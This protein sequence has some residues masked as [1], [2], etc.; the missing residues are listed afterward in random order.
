ML[1]KWV[2]LMNIIQRVKLL[3]IVIKTFWERNETRKIN[4]VSCKHYQQVESFLVDDQCLNYCSDCNLR[5]DLP[6]GF[7]SCENCKGFGVIY[8]KSGD[9][10]HF[11][12]CDN[13]R[14][15]GI[16]SWTQKILS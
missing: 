13:C 7:E 6:E 4:S 3:M 16:I 9:S 8:E 1:Q 2:L 11:E 5:N 15:S 14:G 12:F 10:S